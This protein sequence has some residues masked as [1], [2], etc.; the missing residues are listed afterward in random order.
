V[1]HIASVTIIALERINR[2]HSNSHRTV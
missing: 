1:A 2:S